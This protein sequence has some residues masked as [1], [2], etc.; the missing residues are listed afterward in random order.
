M[1]VGAGVG[2]CE[3]PGLEPARVLASRVISAFDN[4]LN[5]YVAAAPNALLSTCAHLDA[6]V[7]TCVQ[8]CV[9]HCALYM[10]SCAYLSLV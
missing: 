6:L 4:N 9:Q 3:S 2:G 8:Y 5:K 7:C 10:F 1:V